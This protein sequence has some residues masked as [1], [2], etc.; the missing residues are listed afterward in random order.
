M[1][2]FIDY[3]T[4]IHITG[5]LDKLIIGDKI[6]LLHIHKE[7]INMHY[8]FGFSWTGLV[9]FLL[10]M[11]VNI[12][13]AVFPP[14]GEGTDALKNGKY[15]ILEAIEQVSRILYLLA[16]CILISNKPLN[17]HSP[18]LYIS[19]AFLTFYHI[20]WLRYFLG[21]RQVEL[22]GKSF[23]MVSQ[24]L[25]VFPVLYFI[26]AALWMNN[27]VAAIIMVVFGVAHNIVTYRNLNTLQ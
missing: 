27:P 7:I 6:H 12:L 22:L 9:I 10:P 3:T 20:V 18:I 14:T 5:M 2:Q 24:P 1:P 17:Y 16:L 26:F 25:A 15:P 23:L 11:A 4:P 8:H 13:Y 21:G 19:L